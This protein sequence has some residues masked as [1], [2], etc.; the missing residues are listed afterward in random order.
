VTFAKS[1]T[2]CGFEARVFRNETPV[3]VRVAEPSD[4]RKLAA[5][6]RESAAYHAE[7]EPDFYTAPDPGAVATTFAEWIAS[8]DRRVFVAVVE[9]RLIGFVEVHLVRPSGRPS[10]VRPY[11]AAKLGIAVTAGYRRRGIGTRLMRTAEAWARSQGA[12]GLVLD[13]HAANSAAIRLYE[14]VGY[15]IRGLIMAKSL[16]DPASPED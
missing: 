10:M 3:L 9:D 8:P 11:L 14:K 5:L 4:S 6:Y 16:R 2:R 1:P 7:F 13:C 12:E 15:R